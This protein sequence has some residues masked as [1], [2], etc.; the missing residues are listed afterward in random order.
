[1]D[2]YQFGDGSREYRALNPDRK[3][4][5]WT[6]IYL[7]LLG[8]LL[9]VLLN[10]VLAPPRQVIV[11]Q[12][13]APD[14]AQAQTL[15]AAAQALAPEEIFAYEQALITAAKKA[16][17]AVVTVYSSGMRRQVG[18][19][20]HPL[21]DQF[22]GRPETNRAYNSM[23]SGVIVS[24]DGIVYTND[25][26][27]DAGDNPKIT[28]SL[29]DGRQ[30]EAEL[31]KRFTQQDFTILRI[32]GKNLPY[33]EIAPSSEVRPGQ[34]VLAIGNPFGAGLNEG[35]TG[36]EPTI[37]RGIISALD[38]MLSITSPDGVPRYYLHMFQT[39]A[40]INEGNS[41]GALVDIHGRLIGI[42]TAIFDKGGGSLGIG[43]ALPTD[44]IKLFLANDKKYGDINN[45]YTGIQIQ[46]LTPELSEKLGF[47]GAGVLVSAVDG[48]SPGER[49][50]L[51]RG[52]IIIGMN[53]FNISNLQQSI[54]QVQ[55]MFNGFITGETLTLTVIRD[56]K[57][58]E[59]PITLEP[60]PE[61]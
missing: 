20:G 60:S 7:V 53:G 52:D 4:R 44:R 37:T 38:R 23:G 30:F 43:F 48:N 2:K 19:W 29:A 27:I 45:R 9:G 22:Y 32:G 1:M 16:A 12:A 35:L 31:V 40:A 3:R 11:K 55:N 8:A 58:H 25:H 47:R 56:G 15:S 54:E 51:R 61:K 28:V 46:R 6:G 26:V 14:T 36:G 24:P 5:R 49:S 17:P 42:N 39:D 41:G 21:L 34:T 50:G 57:R 18:T 10:S 59:L 13:A 33:V